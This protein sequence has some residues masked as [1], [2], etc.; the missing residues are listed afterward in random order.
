MA[1]INKNQSGDHNFIWFSTDDDFLEVLEEDTKP[2]TASES[3]RK[4]L[5]EKYRPKAPPN[6]LESETKSPDQGSSAPPS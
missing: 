1:E 2:G 4:L 3:Y 5:R 6:G